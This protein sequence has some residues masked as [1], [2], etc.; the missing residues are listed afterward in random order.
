LRQTEQRRPLSPLR[1]HGNA[2]E[3]RASRPYARVR[4]LG[5]DLNF[6]DSIGD[7]ATVPLFYENRIPELQIINESFD[8]ELI[9]AA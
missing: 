4:R 3:S 1:D 7:G 9:Q 8:E 5:L 6:R 2:A